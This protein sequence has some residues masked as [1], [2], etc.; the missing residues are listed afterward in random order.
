MPEAYDETTVRH[1]AQFPPPNPEDSFELDDLR[2]IVEHYLPAWKQACM[3]SH[4]DGIVLH[5]LAFGSSAREMLLFACAIK[6]AAANGKNVHVACG[7]S[8]TPKS[9]KGVPLRVVGKVYRENMLGPRRKET[10]PI[11]RK[12]SKRHP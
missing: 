8:D 1:M 6:F 9:E 10:R 7:K 2:Q 4:T 11:V 12:S 5:E 3:T